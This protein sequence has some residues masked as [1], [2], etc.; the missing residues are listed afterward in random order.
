MSSAHDNALLRIG[1]FIDGAYFSKVSSY[2]YYTH[3]RKARLSLSGLN[4]FIREE[5]ASQ[6]GVDKRFCQVVD[7]HYFRGRLDAETAHERGVL[8]SERLWEDVLIRE[9][10]TLHFMPLTRSNVSS[11]HEEKGIDVWFA[12]EAFELAMYKRFNV[13]VLITGDGDFVPLI[14]KLNTL[15]TRVMLL[16]WDFEYEDNAGIMRT[17]RTSQH[18]INEVTYPVM[19]AD[20]IDSRSRRNDPL[21]NNLFFKPRDNPAYRDQQEKELVDGDAVEFDPNTTYR[22]IIASI[23]SESGFGFVKPDIGGANKFF[24]YKSLVNCAITDLSV[25]D[26]VTFK[27]V[28]TA[29]GPNAVDVQLSE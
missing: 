8:K 23:K 10:V 16:A 15:G 25:G 28:S 24:L 1:L 13:S 29:K 12:L 26:E 5:V 4:D 18:L 20:E 17:T 3:E 19:M 11:D 9:G 6:E 7:A 22:G 27:V 21:I 14:R 2:Y